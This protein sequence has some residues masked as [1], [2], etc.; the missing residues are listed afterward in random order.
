MGAWSL[1]PGPVALAEPMNSQD[2]QDIKTYSPALIAESF[3]GFPGMRL[4]HPPSPSWWEWQAQWE[5]G[6]DF[7]EVGMT[8]FEEEPESW[9]GSPVIADCSLDAIEALWSH[10]TSRHAGVWLHDPHCT[11]HTQGSLREMFLNSGS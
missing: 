4:L 1:I 11:I 5:S 7:I 8:L 6:A 2:L 3:L 10:L 9:G